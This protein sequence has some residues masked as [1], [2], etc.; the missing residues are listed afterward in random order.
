MVCLGNICRSPLAEGIL[1]KITSDHRQLSWE[2][3]SAGV[4][5]WHTGSPPDHRAIQTAARHGIDISDQKARPF[6]LQDFD[7]FDHIL[8]MDDEIRE[9]ILAKSQEEAHWKKVSLLLDY[10]FPGQNRIVPDPYFDGRFEESY[11][12]IYGGCL[13]FFKQMT[14]RDKPRDTFLS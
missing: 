6:Q 3:D 5:H 11:Q 8:V 7:F 2:I 14:H 1:K 4:G 12:L 10:Q 9:S 13:S